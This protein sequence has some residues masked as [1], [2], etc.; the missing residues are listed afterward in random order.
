M[1]EEGRLA[2]LGNIQIFAQGG[3]I[4]IHHGEIMSPVA[5]V[6]PIQVHEKPVDVFFLGF[7]F[8]YR[9]IPHPT[10]QEVIWTVT[11]PIV[12]FVLLFALLPSWQWVGFIRRRK[13]ATTDY[14]K[15][16]YDLRAGAD[17][18]PECG[19]PINRLE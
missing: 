1:V 5:M 2:R 15:C 11:L 3:F 12:F 9:I 14:Q 6:L 7:G 4:Q 13:D 16:G 10:G 17:Q 19:T 18:C 8:V